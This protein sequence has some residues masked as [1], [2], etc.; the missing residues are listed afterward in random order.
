MLQQI[1]D[2]K[3]KVEASADKNISPN[4]L[5]DKSSNMQQTAGQ[6][7]TQRKTKEVEQQVSRIN[8]QPKLLFF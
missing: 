7:L 1:Q 4:I 6:V 8:L 2:I 3:L 5:N